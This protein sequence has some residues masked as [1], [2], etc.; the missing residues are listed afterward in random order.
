VGFYLHSI[1][2]VSLQQSH[3]GIRDKYWDE[4]TNKERL[5]SGCFVDA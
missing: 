3:A 1:D 2:L 4:S 5:L